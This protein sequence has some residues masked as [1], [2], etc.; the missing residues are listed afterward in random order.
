MLNLTPNSLEKGC[1]HLFTIAHE[2]IHAIGFYHMQSASDR[3]DYVKIVWEKIIKGLEYNFDKYS[4]K[5]IS[6]FGAEYDFG[7][8]MHYP[9]DAFSIDGSHTII[10]LQ[11]HFSILKN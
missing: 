3:D 4:N 8:I 9:R 5:E 10:P 6:H 7:S 2:F 1:F 11:V